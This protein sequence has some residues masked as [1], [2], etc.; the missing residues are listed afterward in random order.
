VIL[1]VRVIKQHDITPI[2]DIDSVMTRGSQR[3]HMTVAGLAVP[4][5]ASAHAVDVVI[6][7][8]IDSIGRP[9]MQFRTR[10]AFRDALLRKLTSGAFRAEHAED[11]IEESP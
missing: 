8:M 5:P 1:D 7:P 3:H 11:P 6:A 4:P 2:V 9:G 10:A